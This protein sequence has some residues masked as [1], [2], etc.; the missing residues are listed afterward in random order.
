[1]IDGED[2]YDVI[3]ID[4]WG[5]TPRTGEFTITPLAGVDGDPSVTYRVKSI[6]PNEPEQ[7]WVLVLNENGS[8]DAYY[9]Y[10]ADSSDPTGYGTKFL[11]FTNIERVEFNS[12]DQTIERG[13]D[14]LRW[15][16]FDLKGTGNGVHSINARD[17]GC[18]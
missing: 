12:L 16:G 7:D 2:G 18:L 6:D 11:S 10:Y 13:T 1:M 4:T 8:G 15:A 14:N 17:D 9:S 3:H 5:G